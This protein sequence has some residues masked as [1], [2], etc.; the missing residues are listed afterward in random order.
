[1]S[2]KILI[3]DDDADLLRMIS[4]SLR[5]AG[6]EVITASG[7]IEGLERVRSDKPKLVILDVA[8]HDLSGVE[9]CQ[10]IR[11]NPNIAEVPVVMLSAKA[12][13][14]DRIAGLRTGAD[15]YVA[16]PVDLD[17]LLARVAA[18][19][20]L[21]RRMRAVEPKERGKLFGF[22]GAKGGVG[23]T[24]VA[25]N[26]AAIVASQAKDAIVVELRPYFGTASAQLRL[27]RSEKIKLWQELEPDQITQSAINRCL[28]SHHSGLRVLLAPQDMRWRQ[29]ISA[30][31]TEALVHA[32]AGMADYVI[33][34][35]PA[36]PSESNETALR[37]CDFVGLVLDREKSC[38]A[39]AKVTEDLL[40][41]WGIGSL[42]NAIVVNRAILSSPISVS[43]IRETLQ[44]EIMGVLPSAPDLCAMAVAA[45]DPL[46]LCGQNQPLCQMFTQVIRRILGDET[47]PLDIQ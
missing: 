4:Y 27:P 8:M 21:A 31:C 38:L 18:L 24:T 29:E 6:Y 5:S 26:T 44:T 9:V 10:R 45:G 1:M 2:D 14:A 28:V 36:Q 43:E 12:Q 34:D 20:G 32:L 46:V 41:A 25:L 15:D 39:C 22:V 19:L 7:G 47:S 17:E 23:A 16:K 13:V 30:E 11:G 40:Q 3:V 42:V 35:M 33:F 37:M